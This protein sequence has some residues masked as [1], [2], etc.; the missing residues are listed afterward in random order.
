MQSI[1]KRYAATAQTVEKAI[2][3]EFIVVNLKSK[4]IADECSFPFQVHGI[5][6]SLEPLNKKHY[7][8][9][10]L[11]LFKLGIYKTCRSFL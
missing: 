3:H 8:W 11:L 2:F 1:A 9:S 10:T 4:S 7:Y 5:A 6:M